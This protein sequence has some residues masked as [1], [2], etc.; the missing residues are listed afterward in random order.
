MVTFHHELEKHHHLGE[1]LLVLWDGGGPVRRE[2][3]G[4]G[5]GRNS[6]KEVTGRGWKE[7]QPS[8]TPAW[9]LQ[10]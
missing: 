4:L 3:A 10:T 6:R 7:A 2:E 8:V 1:A 5:Q 9:V